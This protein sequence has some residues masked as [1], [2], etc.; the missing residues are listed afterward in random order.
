MTGLLH[1][2]EFS[3]KSFVKGGGALIVGFSRSRA[4]AAPARPAAADRP[5]REPRPGR[6]ERRSTRGSRSTPTTPRRSSSGRVE[7]GQGSTTGLLMIAAEELD[8]DIEPDAA[9]SRTT[10]NVDAEHGRHAAAARRSRSGG[11]QIRARPRRRRSRRCS[12]WPRRS[13]ACRSRSLTVGKGVVSGG[14][15]TVTYGAAARRQAVQRH[16]S[17]HDDAATP[18][19]GAGEAGQRSTRSSARA[20]AARSTSRRRSPAR[21]PTSTTSAS[22]ACSTAASSGRAARAPTATARTPVAV[23]RRELDHA[24]P[25]RRRSCESGNFLGVVAPKEYDAI[26]AAAQLKVKWADPPPICRQ[27]EPLEAACA[28]CDSGR[29]GAGARSRR[30]TG[31]RRRGARVARA[32]TCRGDVHVPLPDARADRPERARSPT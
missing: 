23:G 14:G 10:P 30:N 31:E 5:V 24:H 7:L 27:R 16:D 22:R 6:P 21:T 3:R 2:K 25:G 17:R 20:S 11:P 28:S 32:K 13:S 15:K 19:A 8:M 18:G 4:R 26:Q 9:T 12:A 29:P 1:E